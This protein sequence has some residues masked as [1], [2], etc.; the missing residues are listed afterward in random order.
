MANMARLLSEHADYDMG[1]AAEA[2]RA[3]KI[4]LHDLRHT[5]A[6]LLRDDVADM[7]S[8]QKCLRHTK[9]STTMNNYTHE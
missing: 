8:I 9:L 4:R 3:P 2:L 6:K 1:A 7:K 5:T